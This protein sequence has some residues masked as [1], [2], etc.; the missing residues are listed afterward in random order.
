MDSGEGQ[1]EELV[2]KSFKFELA[3]RVTSVKE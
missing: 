1:W 3:D 2:A